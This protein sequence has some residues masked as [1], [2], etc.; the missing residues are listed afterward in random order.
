MTTQATPMIPVERIV[1]E[2]GLNARKS[3]DQEASKRLG[4][5]IAKDEL[6]QP[7]TVRPIEDGK[8]ALLAGERRYEAA[9]LEG[10]QKLLGHIVTSGNRLVHREPAPRGSEQDRGG[11]R[12][13]GSC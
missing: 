4:R 12:A 1:V 5:S 2:E 8:Y 7:I 11:R 3:M 9:R 10:I 6:I 13:G